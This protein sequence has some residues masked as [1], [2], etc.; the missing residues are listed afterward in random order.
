MRIG[1]A[2]VDAVPIRV[3][4]GSVHRRF[5]L[6]QTCTVLS[7]HSVAFRVIPVLTSAPLQVGYCPIQPVMYSRCLSAAG[8][9]FLSYP[10]PLGAWPRLRLAY[11][12]RRRRR[13]FHVP[14]PQAATDVGVLFIA[15]DLLV[16]QNWDR[17]TQFLSCPTTSSA[18]LVHMC[19][20]SE[21]K[22]P[23]PF[24]FRWVGVTRPQQGFT[25]VRPVGLSLACR[26]GEADPLDITPSAS[27]LPPLPAAH[28][29]VGTGLNTGRKR[30]YPLTLWK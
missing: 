18:A 24:T 5:R 10:V 25:C 4:C 26:S 15:V 30:Y 16:F 22:T 6:R 21:F 9:R 11:C 2:P 14:H 3:L 7:R 28:V 8:L 29:R 19:H 13:G 17:E 20:R 1:V 27:Q 23:H 12:I